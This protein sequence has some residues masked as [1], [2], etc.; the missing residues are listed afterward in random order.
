MAKNRV[1]GLDAVELLA[2]TS[3]LTDGEKK[4]IRAEVKPGDYKINRMLRLNGSVRVG[5]AYCQNKTAQM[6]HKKMLLAALMLNGVSV[7]AFIRRYLDGEFEI[8]KEQ[9][10]EMT[11]IWKELSEPF[12]APF[13]GKV[14]SDLDVVGVEEAD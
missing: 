2:L 1:N 6:P 12:N 13:K 4:E 14:T 5:D 7:R 9:E 11:A 8:S 3:L 10:A